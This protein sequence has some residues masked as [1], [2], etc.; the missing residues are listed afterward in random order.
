MKNR[1]GTDV[2]TLVRKTLASIEAGKVEIRPGLSNI[3]KLMSRVAPIFMLN[4]MLRT[5]TVKPQK[6]AASSRQPHIS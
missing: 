2:P 3:L 6:Q 5:I 1:K 4:Q